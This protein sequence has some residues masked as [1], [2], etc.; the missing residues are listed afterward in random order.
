MSKT[1]VALSYPDFR[2][3]W[4][5]N[6]ISFAGTRLWAAVSVWHLWQMTR[7]EAAVGLGGLFAI[8]P[9]FA[10]ALFGGLS[11]DR[12][13]RKHLIFVANALMLLFSALLTL[14]T[15]AGVA[16]PALLYATNVGYAVGVAFEQPARQAF[17]IRLVPPQHLHNALSLNMVMFQLSMMLGPAL[18]GP[19]L[20]L[21]GPGAA[22][23]F[24]TLSFTAVLFAIWFI[25]TDGRVTQNQPL[26]WRDALSGVGF[27]LRTPLIRI[28][29]LLDFLAMLF[30]GALALLPVLAEQV[31]GVD[32]VGYGLLAA[33][34]AV[35]AVLGGVFMARAG[36]FRHQGLVLLGA[37]GVLGAATVG[38]GLTTSFA[39]AAFLLATTGAADTVSTVIR[40]MIRQMST[41]DAMRGRMIGVNMMFYQG[42]P[43]LGEF[44]GGLLAG[45]TSITSAIFIGGLL[46]IALALGYAWR[47]PTVRHFNKFDLE[48]AP[49]SLSTIP[50]PLGSA[51]SD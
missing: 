19:I 43:R 40:N 35:G 33:S 36:N 18:A 30:T 5:G 6:F 2:A 25:R 45:A 15:Y 11:A 10:L 31:L 13:N 48:T 44:G 9:I 22:Y 37:I 51:A 20:A 38:L 27:V 17:V 26:T 41:P 16:T 29:M 34:P 32:E 39:L 7:D 24:N 46:T 28:T 4:L 50:A 1:F 21:W 3:L 14:A 47:V 12:F 49:A 23:L 8:L 42:G